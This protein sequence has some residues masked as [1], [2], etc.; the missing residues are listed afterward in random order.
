MLV[1]LVIS[2][3]KASTLLV[4]TST[5]LDATL[6]TA[7]GRG[8]HAS[9]K[10]ECI[11]WLTTLRVWSWACESSRLHLCRPRLGQPLLQI[12]SYGPNH[13]AG[14]HLCH[15]LHLSKA[16]P[17]SNGAYWKL[18]REL[19]SNLDVVSAIR[20]EAGLLLDKMTSDPTSNYGAMWYGWLKRV[21]TQL[22]RCHRHHLATMKS[23]LNH[24]QLKLLAAQRHLDWSGAG[25]G[26]VELAQQALHQAKIE[27]RQHL[28][29]RQFDFH[30]NTNER[31]TAHFFRRPAGSKVP[32]AKAN[33]G[34]VAVTVPSVVQAAFTDHWRSIM[35][36]PTDANPPN[37]AQ[38][39]AVT[40][41]IARRLTPAQREELD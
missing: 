28:Q 32:I 29:D 31:G 39:R 2:S 34:G 15:S 21:K 37:R 27:H 3:P 11:T 8:D 10:A 16:P 19:L 12:A 22:Q 13:Y 20:A 4:V 9:G 5:S 6:D 17:S 23:N 1:Y 38:R 24:L 33:V 41:T 26:D 40:R 36:T 25:E 35:V 30:A 7:R 18:P 14:D